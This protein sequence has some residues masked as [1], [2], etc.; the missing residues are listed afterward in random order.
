MPPRHCKAKEA[1]V[2]AVGNLERLGRIGDREVAGR[3]DLLVSPLRRAA[4]TLE[5]EID[6][7]EIVRASRNM[8]P[9]PENAVPCGF[10]QR[11]LDRR[12][13]GTR[14][15]TFEGTVVD[16]TRLEPDKGRSEIVGPTAEG[17]IGTRGLG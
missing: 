13:V 5:L 11:N 14:D 2:A 10:H 6:E 1:E 7:A 8:G 9:Q 17:P 15:R 12:S 3:T 4:Q 16:F